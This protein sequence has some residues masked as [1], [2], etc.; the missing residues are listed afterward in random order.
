MNKKHEKKICIKKQFVYDAFVMTMI[1]IHRTAANLIRIH[2]FDAAT[3]YAMAKKL[4]R[5]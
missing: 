5:P 2:R 1:R 3:A 4:C